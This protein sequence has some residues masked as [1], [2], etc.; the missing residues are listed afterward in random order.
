MTETTASNDLHKFGRNLRSGSREIEILFR[1]M[2][3]NWLMLEKKISISSSPGHQQHADGT[4]GLQ[5]LQGMTSAILGEIWGAVWEKSRF[6]NTLPNEGGS[7][8]FPAKNSKFSVSQRWHMPPDS[9]D[10]PETQWASDRYHVERCRSTDR[11]A[12]ILSEKFYA[13]KMYNFASKKI[14]SIFPPRVTSSTRIAPDD[15]NHCKESPPQ[16]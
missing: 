15:W 13:S 9:S 11:T 12:R 14:L 3:G 1:R 16:V 10:R 2:V 8:A 7:S 6:L 4:T 5:W